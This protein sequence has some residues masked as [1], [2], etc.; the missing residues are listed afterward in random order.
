MRIILK[1]PRDYIASLLIFFLLV[2]Q[3]LHVSFFDSVNASQDQYRDIVSIYIDTDTYRS[4]RPKIMRYAEDVQNYLGST[5]V[6]IFVVD[7][8]TT[9][10]SIAA[11]NEKLYYEGADSDRIDRLVGTILI[12]NVP[13]PVVHTDDDIFPSMY[14]YVDFVDKKFTLE[15]RSGRYIIV[16]NANQKTIE[17]EIWHGVI[18]PAVGR[19]WSGAVDIQKISSFFDK[20]HD[21]YSKQ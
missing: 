19:V 8:N 12:G 16:E 13:V 10:Q 5:Q 15:E 11:Q 20:S 2:S 1:T 3:T 6:S 18:N 17:P 14:P 21:F 9:V 7:N 4:V